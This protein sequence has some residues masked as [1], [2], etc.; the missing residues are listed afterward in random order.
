[1]IDVARIDHWA[2]SGT[3]LFH[4]ASPL[5]K[6]IFFLL[7]VTAAV[8][9]DSPFPLAAGYGFLL[10][11]LILLRL[12]WIKIVLLSLYAAVFALLYAL[13]FKGGFPVFAL[14]LLKAV[15]PA[16]AVLAV[17]ATTSYPRIFGL[18]NSV[19]PEL[20]AAGLFMTYRS[21]FILL[22]MMNNFVVALRLRGGFSPGRLRNNAAN[23]SRGI[24]MLLLKSVERGSRVHAVMAVRGYGGRISGSGAGGFRTEDWLPL[25]TGVTV[26]GLVLAGKFIKV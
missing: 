16:L 4:R 21:F 10:S 9:A 19:L 17:V 7:V 24:A 6:I 3:S 13:T 23:I 15:T 20:I 14:L 1:M 18:L 5:S 22:D 11:V 2:A 8:L 26:L 12:P 25:G